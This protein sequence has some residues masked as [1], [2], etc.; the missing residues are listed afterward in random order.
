MADT[1]GLATEIGLGTNVE[2]GVGLNSLTGG[3][4]VGVG[5]GAAQRV[6]V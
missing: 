6:G 3:V 2:P 4:G 5:V 1:L